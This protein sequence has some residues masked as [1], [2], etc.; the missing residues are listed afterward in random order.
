MTYLEKYSVAGGRNTILIIREAWAENDKE[1]YLRDGLQEED[2][3]VLGETKGIREGGKK[4]RKREWRM[5]QKWRQRQEK[6]KDGSKERQERRNRKE[7]K[8][9]KHR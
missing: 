8:E 2:I 4:V 3:W 1:A 7:K 5:E 9:A 6:G